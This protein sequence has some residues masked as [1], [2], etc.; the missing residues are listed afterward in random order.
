MKKIIGILSIFL[1]F[2]F[3]ICIVMG[4]VIPVNAEIIESK[5]ILYK[6]LCGI[7]HFL[8]YLPAV[9]FTG[10]VISCSVSFGHNAE[11]ST[12]RFSDAM[13]SRFK[14]VIISALICTA[15]LTI[16]REV[17]VTSVQNSKYNIVNQ[18]K[19]ITEYIQMG[20]HLLNE[21]SY[22]RA[23][24][25]SNA[26]LK[27]EKDNEEAKSIQENANIELNRLSSSDIRF[28]L[29][30]SDVQLNV[31]SVNPINI[32]KE[33]I[34]EVYEC[35]KKA[36]SAFDNSEWFNAHY[37]AELGISLSTLKDPNLSDLRVLST[38]AWNN[39]TAIYN[40]ARSEQQILF[41]K[42]YQGYEALLKNNDLEAYYIFWNLFN[43]SDEMKSDSEVIFYLNVAEQ[44]LTE[45]YFFI[46]ETFEMQ[47]FETAN[48]VHFAYNYKDGSKDVVYFK[49]MTSVKSTG[50]SIQYLRGLTIVSYDKDRENFQTMTV[51]YAKVLPV[52]VQMFSKETK[53]LLGIDEK[54]QY[55][56]YIMLKSIGRDSDKEVNTPV[57]SYLND[58][59]P[60]RYSHPQDYIMLP[61]SY[62][63]FLMLEAPINNPDNISLPSL[64]KLAP[65]ISEYGFSQE[66]FFQALYNR[67]LYPFWILVVFVA[68][69]SFGWNNKI[70]ST[71]YFQ[72][73]WV[74]SFPFMIIIGLFLS[75]TSDFILKLSNAFLLS[76][77][78]SS[79]LGLFLG[80]FVN[81][82]L[83]ILLSI[84]FLARKSN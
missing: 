18:P 47:S 78:G 76:V 61:I 73:S 64:W 57:Y 13:W 62:D 34:S 74:F 7:E 67:L 30:E 3:L 8:N 54:T 80:I 32:D 22:N 6:L 84:Y 27:L 20:N 40:E 79:Y 83:L 29:N 15:A 9:V 33:S 63:D 1:G 38:S 4:F 44:R 81:L 17:L 12:Y 82:F 50:G 68:L 49:G 11:G 16:S 72:F 39:I 24:K 60:S 71:Q 35:Y 10:Y 43:S 42:K 75:V 36:K 23:L 28:K 77:I 45:K 65:K 21:G 56:P 48:N 14:V 70:G 66:I 58:Y 2:G 53:E 69:A 41:N 51:S 52:S 19:I 46:D 5:K 55:V 37:Y 26:V 59:V 25:Y 31:Q